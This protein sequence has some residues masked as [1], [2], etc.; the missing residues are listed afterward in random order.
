MIV[1]LPLRIFEQFLDVKLGSWAVLDLDLLLLFLSGTHAYDTF[2]YI[3]ISL[4]DILVEA[5]SA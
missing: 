2:C 3:T 5:V 1:S 4:V